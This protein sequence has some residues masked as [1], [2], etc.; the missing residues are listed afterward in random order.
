MALQ[1]YPPS[2]VCGDTSKNISL[3]PTEDSS[4]Q[5]QKINSARKSL[6]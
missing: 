2:L 5:T 4:Q 3:N 6:W 1:S